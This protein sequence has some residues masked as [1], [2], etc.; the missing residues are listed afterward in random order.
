MREKL[1]PSNLRGR[2]LSWSAL[3]RSVSDL[4]ASAHSFDWLDQLK[5]KQAEASTLTEARVDALRYVAHC[6][7]QASYQASTDAEF[8]D[9]M[10]RA[11]EAFAQASLAT[12]TLPSDEG[13][14]L[15]HRFRALA[16]YCEA[17]LSND[18]STALD[19]LHQALDVLANM[20]QD[21]DKLAATSPLLLL[22][23]IYFTNDLASYEP[24]LSR[25]LPSLRTALNLVSSAERLLASFGPEL[26]VAFLIEAVELL[27]NAWSNLEDFV[28]RE[29]AGMKALELFEQLKAV[30]HHA[31]DPRLAVG[32]LALQVYNAAYPL[33][34]QPLIVNPGDLLE[35]TEASGDKYAIGS[36]LAANLRSRIYALDGLEDPT[37]AKL[38][39]SQGRLEANRAREELQAFAGVRRFQCSSG[40]VNWTL[41]DLLVSYARLFAETLEERRMLVDEAVN[42]SRRIRKL[43]PPIG[44]WNQGSNLGFYVFEQALIQKSLSERRRLLDEA[45]EEGLA[46]EAASKQFGPYALQLNAEHFIVYGLI[47][48]ERARLSRTARETNLRESME[49]FQKSAEAVQQVVNS[50]LVTDPAAKQ[51]LLARMN[52]ELG[53]T[54][55]ELYRTSRDTKLLDEALKNLQKSSD[56]QRAQQIPIRGAEALTRIGEAYL[57][58]G[59]FEEARSAFSEAASRYLDA[60]KRYP[61]LAVAFNGRASL[62]QA[63]AAT[64]SARAAYLRSD[65]ARAVEL[66]REASNVLRETKS[67]P[68]LIAMYEAWAF[69]AE[70]QEH[71]WMAPTKVEAELRNAIQKFR[72]AET[73]LE[74]Y[75]PAADSQHALLTQGRRLSEAL[76]ELDAARSLEREGR[77]SESSDKLAEASRLFEMLADETDDEDVR[78]SMLAQAKLSRACQEMQKAERTM[79]RDSYNQAAVMFQ[80]VQRA[81]TSKQLALTAGGWA[82]S[83]KALQAGLL[84]RQSSDKAL[85]EALKK[86]LASAQG[87]FVDAGATNTAAWVTGTERMFD[88]LAY[89]GEAESQLD[90]MERISLQEE[91]EKSLQ[92]AAQMFE[93]A[94]YVARQEDMIRHLRSMIEQRQ[95]GTPG[96]LITAPVIQSVS[97]LATQ[98]LTQEL[99]AG[100]EADLAPPIQAALSG[101]KEPLQV[102]QEYQVQLTILNTAERPAILVR[103]ENL[104]QPGLDIK[105]GRSE[106]HLVDGNLE[107]NGIRLPSLGAQELLLRVTPRQAGNFSLQ[108]RIL[109]L[110]TQ[111]DLTIYPVPSLAIEVAGELALR[112]AESKPDAKER[113][114]TGQPQV[115]DLL[116]GGIPMGFTVV[117][118]AAASNEMRTLV[119]SFIRSGLSPGKHVLYLSRDPALLSSIPRNELVTLS[120]VSIG[121][122]LE[123]PVHAVSVK[124]TNLT[125]ILLETTELVQQSEGSDKRACVD[126]LS[127]VLLQHGPL[128]ARKWLS[129]LIRKLKANGFTTLAV[130][131]PKLHEPKESQALL[132]L[133]DGEIEIN[134]R[135]VEGTTRQLLRV[136]RMYD[137]PY[138][139]SWIRLS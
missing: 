74:G 50:P 101:P 127:D 87:Y 130:L 60:S 48:R 61:S 46:Y 89:H 105:S 113:C 44:A 82:A 71:T 7:L 136:R 69:L 115:D 93:R 43:G 129:D 6:Y 4:P 103:V 116:H 18:D 55:I 70:A 19:Y 79:D 72:E 123:G 8:K 73:V 15:E 137:I 118:T 125:E 59:R 95:L 65:Y 24:E 3:G 9:R 42:V 106:Y 88:A 53:S 92:R 35:R 122:V 132:N 57:L 37:E 38:S 13:A 114:V 84:F 104:S 75:D 30:L 26:K 27:I 49:M 131:D 11:T 78:A 68:A 120:M 111:G 83:C 110:S 51:R 56:A 58:G 86:H 85:F 22:E 66:Y 54:Q 98:T 135:E 52:F 1:F 14:Y 119:R 29:A 47:K 39:L 67:S 5:Q 25:R 112:P 133:F 36:L 126:I 96:S 94:G 91:A 90:H 128:N 20:S 76:I 107:L 139:Q 138:T 16:L 117:L 100:G 97:G 81:S 2:L 121:D 109:S 64:A 12:K 28:G 41:A 40:H 124:L 134:E 10:R 62:M 108:P 32:A 33:P 34:E 23:Y 80:E 77:L 99:F 21:V 31:T 63:R 45:Y 17:Q 102:G